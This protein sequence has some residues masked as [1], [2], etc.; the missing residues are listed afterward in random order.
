MAKDPIF[1]VIDHHRRALDALVAATG[2]NEIDTADELVDLALHS[3][4]S[5]RRRS[6]APPPLLDYFA[7]QERDT[8]G[9]TG[10]WQM[11]D[12]DRSYGEHL[13]RHV[14]RALE[15]MAAPRVA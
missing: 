5:Y 13:A 6:R 10:A 14:A 12:D 2:E 11:H 4:P 15:G 3:P 8:G 1:G 7:D 9:S